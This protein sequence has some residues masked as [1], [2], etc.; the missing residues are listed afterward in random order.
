MREFGLVFNE[1]ADSRVLKMRSNIEELG[2][3]DFKVEIYPDGSWV[4]E[5]QNI[6]GIVTGSTNIS[7]IDYLVKDAI[8]T[9]FGI[10]TYLCNDKLLKSDPAGETTKSVRWDLTP[11][12]QYFHVRTAS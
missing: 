4:A 6:E 1:K 8:F 10:P 3:I 9:Y 11:F 5:S 12:T 7:D 2:G